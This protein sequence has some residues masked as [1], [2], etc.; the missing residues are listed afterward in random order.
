MSYLILCLSFALACRTFFSV[1]SML[2]QISV[3]LLT[4]K[5]FEISFV[6]A[7][8]RFVFSFA[9]ACASVWLDKW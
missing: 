4:K 7:I 5:D 1:L 6:S 8:L 2:I 9:L 3:F